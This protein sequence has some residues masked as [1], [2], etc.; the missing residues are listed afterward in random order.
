MADQKNN[1][2]PTD[3]PKASSIAP[4]ATLAPVSEPKKKIRKAPKI[5]KP[6][7]KGLPIAVDILIVVVLIA[8]I[9]GA[10]WGIFALTEYFSTRYA[11][12]QITYT[13]L[14][15]DVRAELAIDAEG[16]CVVLSDT[17][18]FMAEGE[19]TPMGRVQSVSVKNNE[20]GTVDLYV[21]VRT[22]ADYNYTLGYFADKVK[23]AV[24]KAYTYRFSG[25]VSD[26]VI[27]E[28]QVTEGDS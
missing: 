22:K 8:A 25:L 26:A 27:V 24:G 3:D 28:L 12:K 11:Q 13:L 15:E 23:I 16:E 14:A 17:D 7:K 18:V 19:N 9:T 1:I 20:D 10:V 6:A 5:K 4:E 21:V 2:I